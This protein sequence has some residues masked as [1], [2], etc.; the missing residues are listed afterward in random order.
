MSELASFP[1]SNFK[2]GGLS[3]RWLQGY[4]LTG[5]PL[6]PSTPLRVYLEATR[7]E[8]LPARRGLEPL[9]S[10]LRSRSLP[11][12][13]HVYLSGKTNLRNQ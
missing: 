2:Q 3:R 6:L 1:S 8:Q 4:E 10:L 13:R 11:D 7:S 12:P 5:I 9:N